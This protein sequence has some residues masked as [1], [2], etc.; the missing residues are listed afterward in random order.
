[1]PSTSTAAAS[2][3]A[4]RCAARGL[5]ERD[6][7]ART[8]AKLRTYTSA[9]YT[10]HALPSTLSRLLVRRA[11]PRPP[12]LVAWIKVL[13]GIG[14]LKPTDSKG[15]QMCMTMGA[16]G[17]FARQLSAQEIT[18]NYMKIMDANGACARAPALPVC[19][20]C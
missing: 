15:R 19:D 7:H 9:A 11:H 14:G 16:G 8:L 13:Q 4:T 20:G 6:A 12:Q 17:G 2:S 18:A 1:M 5:Q 10:A 3:N